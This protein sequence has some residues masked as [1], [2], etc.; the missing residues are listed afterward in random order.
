M[1]TCFCIFSCCR[2][3]DRLTC[4]RWLLCQ[5]SLLASC[6]FAHPQTISGG[7]PGFGSSFL[8]CLFRSANRLAGYA[9]LHLFVSLTLTG[10]VGK[11]PS[12]PTDFHSMSDL[13]TVEG[14]SLSAA[15]R[16]PSVSRVVQVACAQLLGELDLPQL[17]SSLASVGGHLHDAF[18]GT[19]AFHD[20]Q[21]H[22]QRAGFSVARLGDRS[23]AE[24]DAFRFTA[25]SVLDNL[26]TVY[27]LLVDG[28][29]QVALA[30]LRSTNS[31][32]SEL[33]ENARKLSVDFETTADDVQETLKLALER[34]A[35]QEERRKKLAAAVAEYRVLLDHARNSKAVSDESFEEAEALYQEALR[36]ESVASMKN[37]AMQ[38]AQVATAVGSVF[39]TRPTL[40]MVGLGGVTALASSFEAEVMRVREEKA[41]YLHERHKQRMSRLDI[42]KEIAEL[43]ARIRST[44]EEDELAS[45]TLHSLEDAVAGLRVLS[46]VMSKAE[47]FWS[48]VETNCGRS[49][50]LALQALIESSHD[51]PQESRV[52]LWSS[53]AF[54]RRAIAVYSPW[55]ALQDVCHDYVA[56]MKGTRSNLYQLLDGQGSD[57]DGPSNP[58]NQS[59]LPDTARR[60]L[61]LPNAPSDATDSPETAQGSSSTP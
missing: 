60:P 2:C 41:V 51:L 48:Q 24:L 56:R 34:R 8:A 57:K 22:V 50:S 27:S 54:K 18:L 11:L 42:G 20:L 29:E 32:S 3:S 31:G 13:V 49:D 4:I 55:V 7:F 30:T 44:R 52:A 38:A 9:S 39:S 61:S 12:P 43:T 47:A 23:A 15:R 5:K 45:A 17:V 36:K 21:M 1:Q 37:N 16:P 28:M 35:E 59:S 19:A 58:N 14:E 40:H 10:G 46:S 33:A 53:D 25:S 26:E 6:K